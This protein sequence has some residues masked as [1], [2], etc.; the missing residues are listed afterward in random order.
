MRLNTHR[1]KIISLVLLVILLVVQPG[2]SLLVGPGPENVSASETMKTKKS[3]SGTTSV[4]TG[5]GITAATQGTEAFVPETLKKVNSFDYYNDSISTLSDKR[6]SPQEIGE[7][8]ADY[9]T[10]IGAPGMSDKLYRKAMEQEWT[11]LTDYKHAYSK[12][13]LDLSKKY[14]YND[15][16]FIMKKLSRI[17]GVYMYRIGE[18]TN[19]RDMYALEVDIPTKKKTAKDTIVLTGT[20]H[21][22]ETAGCEFILKQLIELLESGSTEARKVL[23]RTRFVAV[24]CVNPDGRD[25][26]CFDTENYTYSN[27]ELW[28]ATSSG[29]DL[30]RNFPGLAWGQ[31]KEGVKKSDYISNSPKK[32]YYPGPYAGSAPET[33]AMMKFLY[34]YVVVEKAG[35]LVDYHMQG[36]VLYA[37]KPWASSAQIQRCEDYAT[38]ICKTLNVGH[39]KEKYVLWPEVDEYS[40]NATG[41]TLTD[42]A[43][44][45]A[46][47]S[48]FSRGYGFNVYCTARKE[49][50]LITIPR[51]DKCKKKLIPEANPLFA[52]FSFEIGW[53]SKSL[54]YSSTARELMAKEY[55]SF[56]FDKVLYKLSS[57]V[58]KKANELKALPPTDS[59]IACLN[60]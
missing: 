2:S 22:R 25:G 6:Y 40:L 27:N 13:T 54:G 9:G 57:L 5:G 39:T 51:M 31:L 14:T 55:T 11:D 56:H 49:F 53:G 32:L 50:P 37:G 59:L 10:F 36:R 18:S 60:R 38:S 19:G 17:D 15:L 7:L 46:Y 48:K 20:I 1:I 43:C 3:K 47:G 41:S 58:H 35:L 12:T 42:Y 4:A 52:T 24:P 16:A 44:S 23:E 34:H 29:T 28:K 26:V 21:A 8:I 33:R 30:N 45:I